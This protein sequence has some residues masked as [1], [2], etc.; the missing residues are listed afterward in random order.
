MHDARTLEHPRERHVGAEPHGAAQV[1]SLRDVLRGER[2]VDGDLLGGLS[3]RW[4][5]L[6]GHVD[7][8]ALEAGLDHPARVHLEGRERSRQA[9][10]DVEM[11]MVDG[12][13][14][15]RYG[16]AVAG[17]LGPSEPRHAEKSRDGGGA[18]GCHLAIIGRNLL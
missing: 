16:H 11:A 5:E 18:G 14:L 7:P 9:K 3:G 8:P 13:S 6:H 4:S 15:G 10:R 1:P 2:G 17:R 12:A